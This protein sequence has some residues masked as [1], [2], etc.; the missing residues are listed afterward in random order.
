MFTIPIGIRAP[1]SS[2]YPVSDESVSN[3]F[4]EVDTQCNENDMSISTVTG[5]ASFLAASHE[6]MLVSLK[7]ILDGGKSS[8]EVLG[9]WH[10]KM[11]GDGM[12][13][14]RVEFFKDVMKRA[15]EVN[16]RS[17]PLC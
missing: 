2:G 10:Q 11:E 6:T 17:R 5:I 16:F 3:Y 13:S 1:S 8:E 4:E 15:K 7:D 14:F 12:G 9:I